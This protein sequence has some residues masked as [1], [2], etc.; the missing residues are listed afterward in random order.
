MA[1]KT[2]DALV[3][4]GLRNDFY[5][6]NYRKIV[7]LLILAFMIIA[8]LSVGLYYV[9]TNP[10]KP[11]YFATT[12][13]G[14]VTPLVPLNQPN[15][16]TSALLQW[17][18]TAA[19]AAYTYNFVNYRQ[20]LQEASEYFTPDGWAAFMDALKNS[21][22]LD[23][24][25]AKKLIVSAVATGAP[26]IL[27]Q[28]LMEGR[29]S[30]KIQMPMLITYQSASEYSQQSVVVTL[31]IVRIPTLTSARGIGIAQFVVGSG[32]SGTSAASGAPS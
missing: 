13:D 24:V 31:L 14:R 21:N 2:E 28:G 26:V 11:Q 22:N 12:I 10:P 3:T 8:V 29:Y 20:A 25:I 16:S 9:V 18:N 5:R 4:V 17:S 15:L 19:I 27:A 7:W 23:A 32:G 30:W 6:D 1:E